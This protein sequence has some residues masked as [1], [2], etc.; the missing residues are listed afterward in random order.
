M[1]VRDVLA[2]VEQL[3]PPQYGFSWDRIGLQV[4][5]PSAHVDKVAVSLDS[6]LGAIEFADSIGAQVLVAHH[7]VIW[8]PLKTLRSDHYGSRRVLELAQRN[9]ACIAAHT[10]WDCAPKGINDAL[11]NRLKLTSVKPFGI[12]QEGN[13]WKLVTFVPVDAKDSVLDALSAAGAG[14]VGNY[15]RCAF[16]SE[17]TGTFIGREGSNPSI[18]KPGQ[19]EEVAE[20]RLEVFVDDNSRIKVENAL[21]KHHPYEEPAFDWLKLI[22]GG[23]YPVGRIGELTP[24]SAEELQK[25]CDK[26]LQSRSEMWAGHSR[27]IK[28]AAVIGGA[29][30]DEWR[31]AKRA[32]ADCLITGEVPQHVGLEASETDFVILA[33]G[34]YATEQPGMEDM[35]KLLQAEIGIS[36]ELYTPEPGQ[37]GRPK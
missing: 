27:S 34:H 28:R 3:A 6:G 5:D 19:V 11:A 37:S 33:C 13:R 16:W 22:E 10:N 18:G 23:G 29:A 7:P 36:C 30:A 8:E 31:A 32:G 21:R 4:G 35:A 9:I 17:G 12:A 20:V 26:H 2:A 25:H 15:E 1:T 14:V 24:C